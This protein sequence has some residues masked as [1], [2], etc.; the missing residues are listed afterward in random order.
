MS[1]EIPADVRQFIIDHLNSVAQLEVLL[2]LRSDAQRDWSGE[3][4]ARALYTAA[5]VTAGQLADLHARGLLAAAEPPEARYRYGPRTSELGDLVARL[6]DVY[7]ERRVSVI[8][9]IYSKPV[10]KVRTFADAFK[11]RKD[12]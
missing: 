4:V 10:D 1:D 12:K 11:L 6:A 2:L 5:D 3:D 8:T 9:L 7:R